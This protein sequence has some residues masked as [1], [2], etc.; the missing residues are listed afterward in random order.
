MV[1]LG[2]KGRI[3][4]LTGCEC[5]K[6]LKSGTRRAGFDRRAALRYTVPQKGLESISQH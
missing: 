6:S 4:P 5:V 2:S 1:G 3:E